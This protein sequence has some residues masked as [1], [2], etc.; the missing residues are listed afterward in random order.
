MIV[1][2]V[3]DIPHVTRATQIDANRCRSVFFRLINC[4]F[5]DRASIIIHVSNP[6]QFA[7]SPS[8]N[9]LDHLQPSPA[10]TPPPLLLPRIL[11]YVLH[12]VIDPIH[13][14]ERIDS[15]KKQKV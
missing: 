5:F 11:T 9:H 7:V 2:S 8:I 15:P 12:L 14:I 1:A 13:R 3:I 10:T 6:F 4:R